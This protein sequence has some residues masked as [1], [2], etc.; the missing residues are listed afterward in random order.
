MSKHLDGKIVDDFVE[1]APSQ[2]ELRRTSEQTGWIEIDKQ[3]SPRF[4]LFIKQPAW[5][6]A[7][8][9]KLKRHFDMF[10]I[11]RHPVAILASWQTVDMPI[12]YGR[13]PNACRFNRKIADAL[14]GEPDRLRRQVLIIDWALKSYS[15]FLPNNVIRFEDLIRDP[16]TTLA[17]VGIECAGLAH[18]FHNEPPEVRYPQVNF[19]ILTNALWPIRDTICM[20]YP[21]F[22]NA[23]RS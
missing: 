13:M 10:V 17:K 22:S 1:A 12:H 7:V 11:V 23:L 21:E 18:Q 20:F 9:Q 14:D 5:F 15:D 19:D 6:T 16:A 2:A 3:L 4:H 8:A